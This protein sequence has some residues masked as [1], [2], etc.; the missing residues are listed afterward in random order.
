MKKVVKALFLNNNIMK[1][2]RANVL[3]AWQEGN[4]NFS[5]SVSR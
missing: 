4:P 1:Q 3:A 2:A 5:T